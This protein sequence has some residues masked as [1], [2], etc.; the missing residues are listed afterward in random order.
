M[1][2]DTEI[3]E[4]T[5]TLVMRHAMMVQKNGDNWTAMAFSHRHNN[6]VLSVQ[7]T[8]EAAVKSLADLIEGKD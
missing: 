3:T 8:K 6:V 4:E 1:K 2:P 5:A 7:A